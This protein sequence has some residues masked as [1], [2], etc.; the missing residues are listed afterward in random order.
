MTAPALGTPAR[1][2]ASVGSTMDEAAGWAADGAPHGAVVV[3]EH[4]TGGRG[5][6]GR[7]WVAPPGQSLLFTVVLRGLSADRVGLVPLAAGL[8][9]AQA[10][11]AFGVRARVKWPNDVHVDG[12][13]LAGVL[14]ETRWTPGRPCVLLGVGLNVG[15]DAFPPPLDRTATSLRLATGQPTDRLAPL[16]PTLDRLTAALALAETEPAALVAAVEAR[17]EHVGQA[18]TVRDPGTGRVVARGAVLGLAPSGALR[19][20]TEVGTVEVVAGEV[21]LAL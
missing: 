19:L 9:V 3:A 16:G 1:H 21:T 11:E 7:D 13:K 2:L 8:A 15:Q 5:R 20:G 6:H 17:L 18:V 4:Q 14:A 10:S 12:R